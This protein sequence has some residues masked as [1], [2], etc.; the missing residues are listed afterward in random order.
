MSMVRTQRDIF[1]SNEQSSAHA[2]LCSALY[3]RELTSLSYSD[4]DLARIQRR[5][6]SLPFYITKAAWAV[7][8]TPT[9]LLL[10]TQNASWQSD[11]SAKPPSTTAPATL[12]KW[13][14]RHI[15]PGLPL[16][17]LVYA[18]NET[19]VAVDSVDRVDRDSRTLHLNK[20][21][22]F[23]YSG[24]SLDGELARVLKPTKKTVTAAVCGH[25]W[26]THG[27]QIPQPLSLREFM[28]TS[29][30]RWPDFEQPRPGFRE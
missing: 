17:V 15:A 12:E 9:P 2:E 25:R 1:D 3:Q 5:L 30:F 16:P 20:W 7:L 28:L 13:L 21:G 23:T 14:D 18:N 19:V 4:M 22:W 29:L 6:R 8:Q 10:D 27:K 26:S 24:D 11:Q